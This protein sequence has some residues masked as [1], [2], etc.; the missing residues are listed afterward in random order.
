MS[1]FTNPHPTHPHILLWRATESFTLDD[2][3]N[4][5][6][7]GRGLMYAGNSLNYYV[8]MD[9][10]ETRNLPGGL[11]RALQADAHQEDA[12][13]L[14]TVVVGAPLLVRLTVA[15]LGRLGLGVRRYDFA[16]SVEQAEYIVNRNLLLCI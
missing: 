12:H 7:R 11:M 8:V 9:L 15:L 10:S 5:L 1:L 13:Y 14:G 2:Y 3:H 4:A 16:A 6:H